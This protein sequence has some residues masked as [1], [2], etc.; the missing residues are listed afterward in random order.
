MA[1]A[2][3]YSAYAPNGYYFLRLSAGIGLSEMIKF[4]GPLS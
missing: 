3:Q 1:W 4:C 2:E